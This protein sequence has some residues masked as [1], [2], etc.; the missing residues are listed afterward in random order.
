MSRAWLRA[1]L[2]GV[3][4]QRLPAQRTVKEGVCGGRG[5]GEG[6]GGIRFLGFGGVG[7]LG[8]VR[9]GG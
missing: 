7:M 4:G 9:G 2:V 3:G 6:W 5:G 8:E 1:P